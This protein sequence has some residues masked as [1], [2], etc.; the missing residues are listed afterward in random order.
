MIQHK[1]G[2]K[3]L[4]DKI[5]KFGQLTKEKID[6]LKLYGYSTELQS[7]FT[8]YNLSLDF[9]NEIGAYYSYC[10]EILITQSSFVIDT[11]DQQSY[12]IE[13]DKYSIISNE[14]SEIG[15]KIKLKLKRRSKIIGKVY[16]YETN[17]LELE[18]ED[19]TFVE[20]NDE[21]LKQPEIKLDKSIFP[22]CWLYVTG[23]IAAL[24]DKKIE[25]IL[26]ENNS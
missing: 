2:Q 26:N 21:K 25:S 15:L 18:L 17:K 16:N 24:R 20:I 10:K 4:Y 12:M 22:D 5:I 11:F 19:G 23:D 14:I 3:W 7:L 8:K 1:P 13:K 9:K 6:S